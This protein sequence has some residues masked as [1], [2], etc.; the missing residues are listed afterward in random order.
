MVRWIAIGLALGGLCTAHGTAWA[1]EAELAEAAFQKG[2]TLLAEGRY[3][4]ACKNFEESQRTDPASG[5]LLALAYCQELSGL[6]AS[7]LANYRAAAELA[8]RE[9]QADRRAAATERSTE[10]AGRVSELT[11]DVPPSVA[12]LQGL[13]VT[14]NGEAL[15][16]AMYGAPLP[17]NGGT[18]KVEVS[19]TGRPSWSATVTIRA[20]RDRKTLVVEV[21]DGASAQPTGAAAAK[22]V[23][24]QQVQASSPAN[25]GTARALGYASMGFAG[26]ALVGLGLGIGFGVSAHSK[27]QAS[28]DDGH[29][30]ETGC[31]PQGMELRNDALRAASVSTWSFV[32][33]GVCAATSV[34]LFMASKSAQST[35][36]AHVEASASPGSAE[37]RLVGQF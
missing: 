14:L 11:I 15:E 27:N 33:G 12:R 18:H 36:R 3:G 24:V 31:D 4:E 10:M 5:T 37:L 8:Q 7:A 23:P 34:A 32:V 1:G 26:G 22:P 30:D 21:L 6:L 25:D 13:R 20:E 17:V 9:G 28:R 35:P 29:C 2:R 16:T 19:V